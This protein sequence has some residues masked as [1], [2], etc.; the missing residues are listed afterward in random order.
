MLALIAAL[1]LPIET[2]AQQARLVIYSATDTEAFLP[3]VQAYA[4]ANPDQ[5]IEYRE[6]QTRDLYETML[7]GDTTPDLVISPAMDLQVDL[8]NRGMAQPIS[9]TNASRLP[10][11]AKWR[12]ELFGL[13]FEPAIVAFDPKKIA[14][15]SFPRTHQDLAGFIRTNQDA[16]T[17]RIGT[18]DVP[19]SGIGYLYA[20]QEVVQGLEAQRMTEVLGRADTQLFCCT[21]LMLDGI[22]AGN[23]TLAVSLI[24][25]YA[26]ARAQDNPAI[27]V[28]LMD[29]YNLVMSRSVF[30]PKTAAAPG[31]ATKFIDFLISPAGQDLMARETQLI[32]IIPSPSVDTAT[33]AMLREYE[34]TFLP[35]PLRPSLLTYLDRLKMQRFIDGW[36]DAMQSARQSNITGR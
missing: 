21:S 17:R 1:A 32:P 19:N 35:I 14:P 26:L 10:G 12:S 16:L 34:G 7:S 23:L 3:L 11:W 31:A 2:R 25:S 6:F 36:T 4:A 22:A 24:G 28:T 27:A 5:P 20:T 18:Y 9:L 29:D 13:T 30:V 15:D 33:L 8:V